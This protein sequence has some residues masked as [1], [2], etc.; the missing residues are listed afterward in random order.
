M[1]NLY[2]ESVRGEFGYDDMSYNQS[3]GSIYDDSE[4]DDLEKQARHT[5]MALIYLNG[6]KQTNKLFKGIGN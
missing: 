4:L 3:V 6:G 2:W 1:A 5:T